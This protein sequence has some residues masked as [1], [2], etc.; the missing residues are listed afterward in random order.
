MGFVLWE[1]SLRGTMHFG[2]E[3]LG[4]MPFE[5]AKYVLYF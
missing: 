1:R 2:Q 5:T 3:K 4:L